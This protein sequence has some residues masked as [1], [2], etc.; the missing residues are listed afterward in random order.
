M[1][2]IWN[3]YAEYFLEYQAQYKNIQSRNNIKVQIFNYDNE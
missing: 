3:V 1:G 2:K